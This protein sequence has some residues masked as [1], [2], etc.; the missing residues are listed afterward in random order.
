MTYSGK[1]RPPTLGL[2]RDIISTELRDRRQSSLPSH[3]TVMSRGSVGHLHSRELEETLTQSHTA[4]QQLPDNSQ[5]RANSSLA[6][7]AVSVSHL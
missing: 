7:E 5:I 1:E 4:Q 2:Q 3:H 6:N